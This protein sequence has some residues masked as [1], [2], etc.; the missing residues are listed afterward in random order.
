MTLAQTIP[1][2]PSI[3]KA[4][5]QRLEMGD[6]MDQP[7][8]HHRYLAMPESFRAELVGGVVY[9]PSPLKADHG[10]RHGDVMA[11]LKVYGLNTPGTRA[12]DN[13]TH[14]LGPDS[15]LQPDASLLRFAGNAR[16]NEDGYIQGTPEFVVEVAL[17][18]E[19]YDLHRKRADYERHGVGEYLVLLLREQ[20]AVWFA[21]IEPGVPFTEM[22]AGPDG[23]HR[24]IIYPGLWLDALALLRG[25]LKRVIEI[26][27]AGLASPEHAAFVAALLKVV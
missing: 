9:V 3:S 21:R 1:L 11:W 5:V 8:F 20:R 23:I 13:A 22:P 17:A 19:S 10:D 6:E 26:L 2:R 18:S 15:E 14:I 12:L 16:E 25:D 24:S 4:P 27:D 7:T